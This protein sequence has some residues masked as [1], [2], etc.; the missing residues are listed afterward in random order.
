MNELS[1]IY[2]DDEVCSEREYPKGV[3][4]VS[5]EIINPSDIPL[6]LWASEEMKY[7]I[8]LEDNAHQGIIVIICIVHDIYSPNSLIIVKRNTQYEFLASTEAANECAF[9]ELYD[10]GC[11]C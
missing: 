11:V 1:Q 4:P 7:S 8:H 10:R 6:F 2:D 5:W 3:S 9:T